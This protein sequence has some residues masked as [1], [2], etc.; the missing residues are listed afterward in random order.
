ME[1]TRKEH[2]LKPHLPATTHL[3]PRSCGN[4]CRE[5][6]SPSTRDWGASAGPL[7]Q[8][9]LREQGLGCKRRALWPSWAV[10]GCHSCCPWEWEVSH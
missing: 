1:A 8:E 4:P 6:R 5:P 2:S 9:D 10:G 3:T 7:A